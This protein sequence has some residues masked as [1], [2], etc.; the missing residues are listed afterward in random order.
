LI[1]HDGNESI[2]RA[3]MDLVA[4]SLMLA[5]EIPEMLLVFVDVEPSR[6][7]YEYTTG[8]GSGGDA[9]VDYLQ[10]TLVPAIE[11]RYGA[12]PERRGLAGASLGGLISYHAARRHPGF[13]TRIGGQSPSFWWDSMSIVAAYRDGPI[14]PGRFY[15][16]SG[17]PG[18]AS[19]G[20]RAMRDAMEARGY[21][22]R[23]LEDPGA[24]HDWPYWRERF[25]DLLR[26]L[27]A[28]TPP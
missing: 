12:L 7:I 23:Y 1:V 22:F 14:V 11:A 4:E 24:A 5:G 21:T 20:A 28:P 10:G 6:R 2:T 3:Q 17:Y 27:Y 9:Y 26:T 16:D 18:D 13:W 15:F 19:T 25:D 8:E